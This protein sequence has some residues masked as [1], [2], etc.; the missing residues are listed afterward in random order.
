MTAYAQINLGAEVSF[1]VQGAVGGVGSPDADLAASIK[2]AGSQNRSIFAI[3]GPR[4]VKL[5][6]K[7][8]PL[9]AKGSISKTI[10]TFG[11][12]FRHVHHVITHEI[13][14]PYT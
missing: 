5:P 8:L 2:A 4:T 6:A 3:P 13:P 1:L 11:D 9:C 7:F 12:L 14:S 10:T